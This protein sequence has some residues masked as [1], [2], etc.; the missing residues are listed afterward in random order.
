MDID[1]KQWYILSASE[2]LKRLEEQFEAASA[3]RVR[4][5]GSPIEYFLPTCVEQ[6]SLFG[7]PGLRRKK[8]MGNYVFV[9]DSYKEILEMKRLVESVWLLPHPDHDS[10]KKRYMTISDH[11]MEVFK[12]IANAYA[13]ELP[14]YPIGAVD[15]EEGD[16]VEIV[17]GEFDGVTGTLRCSQGR[18]GGRVMMAIGNLFLVSTPEIRPQYIRILQFGKGNR[19]PYR[20]F[21]A[22]LPRAI[23]AL[24]HSLDAAREHA[25]T[26]DDIAAMSI[27]TGRFEVLQPATVNIA[28]QHATLMLM[29]YAALGDQRKT[30]KW[31]SRCLEL[32]PKVKSDT[33][34]AWQLTFMFAATGNPQL[35]DSARDI[36]NAWTMAPNDR[37]RSLIATNLSDFATI[38]THN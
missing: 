26:T 35:R 11:E 13:N 1:A 21:E 22:Q 37:K 34:R 38:H 16:H 9:R 7:K 12:L 5:G 23:L 10:D 31:Y 30:G 25:L 18:N 3:S 2:G 36:V 15:L 20:Q 29:S 6:S 19:H 4:K 27:F 14:C 28:S 33:Q 32:L 17:G 24:N 8:L